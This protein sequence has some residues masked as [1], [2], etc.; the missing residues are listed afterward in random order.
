MYPTY[1]PKNYW[2]RTSFLGIRWK[3]I[4]LTKLTSF[5]LWT[6]EFVPELF[7]L[8]A[9]RKP[10]IVGGEFLKICLSFPWSLHKSRTSTPESSRYPREL[11][12]VSTSPRLCILGKW[13]DLSE[14]MDAIASY[15]FY[16]IMYFTVLL[17]TDSHTLKSWMDFQYGGFNIWLLMV[18]LATAGD[19]QFSLTLVHF[20]VGLVPSIKCSACLFVSWVGG[21]IGQITYWRYIFSPNFARRNIRLCRGYSN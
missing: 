21:S 4:P 15:D 17:P 5:L 9:R 1:C 8:P 2:S 19:A 16:S 3:L 14:C 12:L 7:W 18:T 20:W 6:G 13:S 11:G 10:P